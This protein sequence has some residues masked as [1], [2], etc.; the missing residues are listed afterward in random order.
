[1]ATVKCKRDYAVY[2]ERKEF[3]GTFPAVPAKAAARQIRRKWN[4]PNR[5]PQTFKV[6]AWWE[7]GKYDTVYVTL[8]A[9]A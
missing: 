8:K 9:K 7:P 3:L 5:T 2:N 4:S 6:S 1:M